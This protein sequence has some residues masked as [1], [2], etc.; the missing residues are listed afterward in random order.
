V[1]WIKYYYPRKSGHVE[2]D[3]IPVLEGTVEDNVSKL[4]AARPGRPE[5]SFRGMKHEVLPQK[6][7]PPD[8]V[9]K[10]VGRLDS[11]IT[12]LQLHRGAVCTGSSMKRRKFRKEYIGTHEG[13]G[14]RCRVFADAYGSTLSYLYEM[15]AIIAADFPGVVDANIEVVKYGGSVRRRII[16]S[17]FDRPSSSPIPSG[18]TAVPEFDP[19]L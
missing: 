17:E 19:T 15:R 2:W 12:K 3:Y 9:A 8:V 14:H 1:L 16:G 6:E 5:E 4:A 10:Y 13:C 11:E 18:W 7:V